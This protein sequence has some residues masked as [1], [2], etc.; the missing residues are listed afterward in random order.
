[1]SLERCKLCNNLDPCGHDKTVDLS[2][3][4]TLSLHI[5]LS[6][7]QSD[8]KYCQL[9]Q[10]MVHHFAPHIE[11]KAEAPYIVLDLEEGVAASVEVSGRDPG[12]PSYS[13]TT[14]VL[15]YVYVQDHV[16]P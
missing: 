8:C 16:L 10:H 13:F 11:K 5:Q 3:S 9:L 4:K 14:Y 7:L 6:E 2:F 1:M 15:F 12:A